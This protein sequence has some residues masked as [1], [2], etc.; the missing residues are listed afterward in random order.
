MTGSLRSSAR[1][2]VAVALMGVL[3]LV[4]LLLGVGTGG[5]LPDILNGSRS[6][7]VVSAGA[8]AVTGAEFRKIFDQQKQKAEQQ[9]GQ[10]FTYDFLVR[11]G[12]DQSLINGLAQNTASS[13]LM[14]RAGIVPA[15]ELIDGIIK[16][17]PDAF[18]RVTGKFSEVQFRQL[19]AG[20]GLTVKQVTEEFRDQLAEQEFGSAV[21]DGLVAPRAF[22]AIQAATGLQNRDVSFFTLSAATMAQ[23][24]PPSDAELLAFERAKA[25]QLTRPE[26]RTITLVRFS[27]A[28]L[29]AGVNIDKAQIE[30]AFND[31]RATLSS[32]ETRSLVQIP[33]RD[34]RQ[35][36]AV[37]QALVKGQD[38]LMIARALH[39]DPIVY[40]DKAQSEIADKQV[41]AAA[42]AMKPGEVKL[43]Q[44]SLGPAA[45]KL[46]GVTAAHTPTLQ[47]ESAK[48]E[49]DLRLKAAQDQA[50][51]QSEAF[52]Q[53]RQSGLSVVAAAQKV[54]AQAASVGPFDAKGAGVDGQPIAEINDKIAKAAF[55]ANANED[56]DLADA[57]SS[58]YFALH[59]DKVAPP[60]LPPL[61]EARTQLAKAWMIDQIT[62]A[63]RAKAEGLVAEVKAGKSLDA[64]AASTGGKVQHLQNLELV[65]ARQ[66]AAMGRDFLTAAFG[67]KPGQPF[68][69]GAQGGAYIGKIDTVRAAEPQAAAAATRSLQARLGQDYGRDI[70]DASRQAAVREMHL[71]V[72]RTLALQ[73][74]GLDPK[75]YQS[76]SRSK[77]Q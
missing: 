10:T 22:A 59:V 13:E 19:L 75:L 9:N 77:A 28:K 57:G 58:D 24:H 50:Y 63:F 60:A 43:V 7:A 12:F 33:L 39:V 73:S 64:V 36:Q 66:Y 2:P 67:T 11:N 23:P 71:Q 62:T 54:G 38:P 8:H 72:N 15:P 20:Q 69:A 70:V 49:A 1:N 42:F 18:D 48:I 37:G 32:A 3:I 41:A 26:M 34:P 27:A 53:A 29:V 51:K 44:G 30:K 6:D 5:R 74:L 17:I 56:T 47:T 65:N 76:S 4:F 61:N 68:A 45:I 52:D 25:A 46:T 14:T 21:G 55:A 31:R 40:Q 16:Q 35:A